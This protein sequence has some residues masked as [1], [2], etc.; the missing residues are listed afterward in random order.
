MVA[1]LVKLLAFIKHVSAPYY[2]L[3]YSRWHFKFNGRK[4]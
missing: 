2:Y 3:T 1:I 4:T